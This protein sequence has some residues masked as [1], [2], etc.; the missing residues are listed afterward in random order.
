M[1]EYE[2]YGKKSGQVNYSEG[3]VEN[4]FEQF[5]EHFHEKTVSAHNK[6]KYGRIKESVIP[7][8]SSSHMAFGLRHQKV[9]ELRPLMDEVYT[10]DIS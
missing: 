8:Q 5:W 6:S 10:S 2:K 1:K 4:D 7:I 3:H 9:F